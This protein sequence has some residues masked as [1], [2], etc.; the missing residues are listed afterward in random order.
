[1]QS[2]VYNIKTSA[3]NRYKEAASL[4]V[5]Y[6]LGGRPLIVGDSAE[7]IHLTEHANRLSLFDKLSI[8]EGLYSDDANI[9]AGIA[10]MK[11]QVKK[12]EP[13]KTKNKE[14]Q[15]TYNRIA[16]IVQTNWKQ[17]IY[18]LQK[19]FTDYG[20]SA[21]REMENDTIIGYLHTNSDPEKAGKH[22]VKVSDLM[23]LLMVD[24]GESSTS[25]EDIF[26]SP[27]LFFF[28][29]EFL[30]DTY[31]KP[32]VYSP[33]DE[34]AAD[35]TAIYLHHCFTFPYLNK[36][37]SKDLQI[38]RN[39]LHA[40]GSSHFCRAVDDWCYLCY[41]AEAPEARLASFREAVVPAAARLQQ[42]IQNNEK[43]QAYHQRQN[44]QSPTEVWIGELPVTVI[45]HYYRHFKALQDT[46]WQK[47]EAL[48]DDPAFSRQRWPVM[49]LKAEDHSELEKQEEKEEREPEVTKKSTAEATPEEDQVKRVKKYLSID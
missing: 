25:G 21:I 26:H 45:W 16:G 12:I 18:T 8:L 7:E 19:Q 22:E 43:L 35:I 24:E 20:F 5:A 32:P 41:D 17:Y 10:G 4:L 34:E 11:K 30:A 23:Q 38:I 48:K 40:A 36:L 27:E 13:L 3:F 29:S 46:T 33:G 47:L 14:M 15:A 39:D 44:E 37:E 1:M 28:G 49:M 9:A 2:V 6:L 31:E 42:A